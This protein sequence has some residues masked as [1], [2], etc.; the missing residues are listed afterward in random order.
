VASRLPPP[1]GQDG[2]RPSPVH[3]LAGGPG[4]RK[5]HYGP[6]VREVL[7]RTGKET[8]LVAYLGAATDDDRRFAGMM[9]GLV[10]AAGPCTFRLAP[11]VGA[12][13]GAAREVIGAADVVFVGGGDVELGMRRLL[14]RDLTETL[15]EKH[16][17]GAPFLGISAGAILLG[18]RWIR[19]RD[20]DD[21]ASAEPFDCLGLA[22]VLCDCHGEEDGWAELRAL[23]RLEAG[24][25]LGHGIRAGAALR[26]G[27][28]GEVEVLCGEVDRFRARHGKV[29]PA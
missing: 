21:D 11:V 15:R 4:T 3:L 27:A 7:Q 26:V 5:D 28:G 10:E 17:G 20:P 12:R 25:A 24:S 19:W 6:I 2:V 29:V 22:P 9:A 8:P 1:R 16:G 13:A 18:R 14:E 23:L